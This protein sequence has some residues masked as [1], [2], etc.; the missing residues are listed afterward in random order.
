[1]FLALDSKKRSVNVSVLF[2]S[3]PPLGVSSLPK[4]REKKLS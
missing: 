1:M 2:L 4:I 3:S